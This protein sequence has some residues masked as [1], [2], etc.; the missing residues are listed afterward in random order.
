[1]MFGFGQH[2]RRQLEEELK[3]IARE[4][5]SLGVERAWLS[6]DLADGAVS[7]ESELELV[8]VH[9]SDEPFRRRADF[10][11]SHLRPRVG[12]RFMV[13][14]PAEFDKFQDVDPSLKLAIA[15]GGAEL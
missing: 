13:Y 5:P 7:P 15:G 12:T 4:L 3:R 6:G 8:V 1:M 14:T 2:R 11:V 10:F 9:E